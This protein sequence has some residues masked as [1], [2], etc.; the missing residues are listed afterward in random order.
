[1]A[2]LSGGG[3]GVVSTT[4]AAIGMAEADLEGGSGVKDTEGGSRLRLVALLVKGM[5]ATEGVATGVVARSCDCVR[6]A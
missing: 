4:G 3:A 1:M 2:P 6:K 5:R